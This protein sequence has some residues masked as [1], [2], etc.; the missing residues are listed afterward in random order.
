MSE[1]KKTLKEEPSGWQ[2]ANGEWHWF[3]KKENMI[4]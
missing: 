2:D 1:K 3:V 4:E